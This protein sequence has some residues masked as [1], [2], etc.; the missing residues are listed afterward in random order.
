MPEFQPN[1]VVGGV[2]PTHYYSV[3][4]G[5]AQGLGGAF[6]DI[7]HEGV[8]VL[9]RDVL[10]LFTPEEQRQQ[11]LA[12]NAEQE[13]WLK[14]KVMFDQE[15]ADKNP[16]DQERHRIGVAYNIIPKDA[17]LNHPMLYT[18]LQEMWKGKIGR[19]TQSTLQN[20]EAPAKAE[21]WNPATGSYTPSVNE[22]FQM[23]PPTQQ[24]PISP[25]TA[26]P[27]EQGGAAPAPQATRVQPPAGQP[28]PPAQAPQQ[29]DVRAAQDYLAQQ[30]DARSFQNGAGPAGQQQQEA[31]NRAAITG[32][33]ALPPALQQTNQTLLARQSALYA[34]MTKL[35]SNQYTPEAHAQLINSYALTDDLVKQQAS[36]WA[37]V[38]GIAPNSGIN[39]ENAIG[40]NAATIMK[41]P[42]ALQ[43][44]DP[45]VQKQIQN[46]ATQYEQV[47]QE[48]GFRPFDEALLQKIPIPEIKTAVVVQ[49]AIL[50]NKNT[51]A[52]IA[53]KKAQANLMQGQADFNKMTQ[54]LRKSL[55]ASE[56]DIAKINVEWHTPMLQA[57]LQK[58]QA[59][60]KSSLSITDTNKAASQLSYL[61]SL[62]LLERRKLE[63]LI[64]MTESRLSVQ[65]RALLGEVNTHANAATKLEGLAKDLAPQAQ[66][67]EVA[68]RQMQDCLDKAR[69][70]RELEQKKGKMLDA[71]PDDLYKNL[72]AE[73]EKSN[74][75]S[76]N[77]TDFRRALLYQNGHKNPW[78]GGAAWHEP[79]FYGVYGTSLYH[80]DGQGNET[81]NLPDVGNPASTQTLRKIM[82]LAA[83]N[84]V[85][86]GHDI[87][88]PQEMWNTKWDSRT[89][90]VIYN[91]KDP[92]KS[93]LQ[94]P[95]KV[96]SGQMSPA[97]IQAN[98]AYL[99][100]SGAFQYYKSHQADVT[101]PY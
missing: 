101:A 55:L 89:G 2:Q 71:L 59:D 46:A 99:L 33:S 15:V 29:G 35:L 64:K 1:A 25:Q 82:V 19:D 18:P 44:Y 9:R 21:T 20:P 45:A 78:G 51:V 38:A 12:K 10:G 3:R 84:D 77:H 42:G 58:R 31:E 16:D 22:M 34:N 87:H 53:Q 26:A 66:Y 30:R 32:M 93:L 50:D 43:Q 92:G 28:Q 57:E 74:G 73:W 60:I 95:A 47:K 24:P 17:P 41:T 88:T 48:K 98:R 85:K 27:Q 83:Y 90:S 61:S 4:E 40:L 79:S 96:P 23:T 5:L 54:D 63:P 56:D 49:K 97:E 14:N 72:Q 76:L 13:T 69:I 94:N 6:G 62:E 86:N 100:Y 67:D 68:K 70:E 80:T 39:L 11:A 81:N 37:K 7:A 36:M 91:P 65:S 52:E 75:E 8:G